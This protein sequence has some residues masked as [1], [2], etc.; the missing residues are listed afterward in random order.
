MNDI[1]R[2][3][4]E[5]ILNE[6]STYAEIK[7]SIDTLYNDF[8][9][10]TKLSC[11]LEKAEKGA[12][13]ADGEILSPKTAAGS[14]LDYIRTTK[15]LRGIKKAID[16][17][18]NKLGK[19]ELNIM[20]VQPGPYA[21]LIVPL[22]LIYSKTQLSIH[23]IGFY[24]QSIDSINL[25]ISH[26]GLS[27]FFSDVITGNP[28]LYENS[29]NISFDM[30]IVENIQK[31]LFS[32]PQIAITKHFVQFLADDGILIPEEI[33]V[34]AAL[35]DLPTELVFSGNKWTNFW[36]KIRRNNAI[37]NRIFLN[38]LFV[39]D[40][41]INENY[42]LSNLPNNQLILTAAKV[43]NKTERMKNLILLTE[44]KIFDDVIL[45]EEDDTGMTKLFYDKN[46]PS[47]E[48]GME[49]RFAYQFGNQPR[50]VMDMNIIEK[51]IS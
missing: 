42:I 8:A 46:L 31:A 17:Q 51:R 25:L 36:L 47:V 11:K 48:E 33:K 40:K 7:D 27:D 37:S 49:I 45:S 21:E 30:L 26:Y 41:N 16:Y 15:F 13:L 12:I 29:S 22:L 39:L 23:I 24:Q 2:N 10:I 43:K 9:Q 4:V 19:N 20:Y 3:K 44:I 32:E 5:I 28:L 14:I 34:T 18:L 6:D 50:F 1:I 35:A 38:D